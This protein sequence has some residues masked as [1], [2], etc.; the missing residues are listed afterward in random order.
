MDLTN[1][2]SNLL[3]DFLSVIPGLF[4]AIVL[5]IVGLIIAK[6]LRKSVRTV[7]EK[8]QIDKL[9]EQLNEIE[10]VH[11]ANFEIK[12]SSILSSV[13]YYFVLILFLVAATDVLGMAAIS[14]LV[15]N[16][17]EFIPNLVVAMIIL[18]LGI[19]MA[20]MIKNLVTTA[21]ES[22]GIPSGKLIG[23]LLFYFLFI[24]IVILALTQAG[25]ET[26]FL[27]RNLS[28]M[29]AGIVFAFALGYGLAS[30]GIMSNFL[31][32]YYSSNLINEGDKITIDGVT[33]TIEEMNKSTITLATPTS[34]IVFPLSKITT[35]K[36]E[37]HN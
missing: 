29:I 24:N 28:I 12:I 4:G 32:S 17:F 8:I 5:I 7:L 37:I 25:I 19:L 18:V 21:C 20:D 16:I 3:S 23:N 1:I 36:I 11:K 9:S 6:I 33:G 31:A 15:K 34:K 10:I 30:K 22:L 14:D 2:F 35:E 26:N 27:S 13:L